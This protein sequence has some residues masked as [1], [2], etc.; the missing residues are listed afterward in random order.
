MVCVQCG[1]KTQIINSRAQLRV[2]QVWRRRK[3]LKCGTIFSTH[4]AAD[5]SAI[6]AVKNA[7]GQL[8]PFSRDK[9]FLSLL[10]SCQHR[11][12]AIAD[13]AALTETVIQKLLA[14]AK[15]GSIASRQIVQTTQVALNRFDKAASVHYAAFHKG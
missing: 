11:A 10:R 1:Q 7:K 8:S 6:W 3:C 13:A 5:Y 2:N 4:E 12:S 14:Q 9:L 15:D